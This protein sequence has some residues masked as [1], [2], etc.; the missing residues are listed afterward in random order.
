MILREIA[1]DDEDAAALRTAQRAEIAER[2][3][4][5]DSEPGTPPSAA[6]ITLFLVAYDETGTAVGCGGLRELD[7]TEGE[8][9]RM[10]VHPAAR[11]TGV[12]TAILSRLE[13]LARARGWSRL[14][15]ETGDR[16]PDAIRFYQREGFTR[17]PNFGHYVGHEHSLCFGKPLLA[18]DPQADLGCE[19]CE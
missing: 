12:S 10:F 1:W 5:P 2:Y 17:I 9:K 19:G 3:G 16:Q 4:T 15:L 7:R 18:E 14:V 11:G 13:E 6:D 8:V